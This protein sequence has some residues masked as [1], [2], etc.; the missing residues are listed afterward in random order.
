[1]IISKYSPE[2]IHIDDSFFTAAVVNKIR[3]NNSRIWINALGTPDS[4]AQKG[5]SED[6]F[7]PLV[8]GGANI[9]QTDLPAELI[10]FLDSIKQR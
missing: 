3:E 5:N 9:I 8:M 4:I 10:Q 7:S 2:V 6:A 1:M